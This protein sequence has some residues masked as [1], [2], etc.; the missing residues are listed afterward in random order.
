MNHAD[1]SITVGIS[2]SE[3]DAGEMAKLGYG[4]VHL[5]DAMVETARQ[6]LSKGYNLAYGGDLNYSSAFNFAD[7]LFQL[8]LTYGGFDQRITN[9]TAFPL[10]TKISR[11]REAEISRT[12]RIVRVNPPG[13]DDRWLKVRYNEAT[14]AD[15]EYLDQIFKSED[16][17]SKKIWADSLTSMRLKMTEVIDCRIAMGGKTSGYKGRMPGIWE[18]TLLAAKVAKPVFAAGR[19]GG[20]AFQLINWLQFDQTA[21]NDNLNQHRD[22]LN[23]VSVL[24]IDSGIVQ[25]GPGHFDEIKSVLKFF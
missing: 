20:A 7:L 1:K 11:T 15:R 21:D 19:F 16:P 6:L 25:I 3:P 12:A 24:N 5:Q 23:R 22:F 13:I 17:E 2:I 8:G 14:P 4:L 9:Y 10:Y 18:E